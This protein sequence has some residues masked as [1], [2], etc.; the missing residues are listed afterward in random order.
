M[1]FLSAAT[2]T[3]PFVGMRG[4]LNLRANTDLQNK[5]DVYC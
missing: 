4:T 2:I 5:H 3:N 1:R